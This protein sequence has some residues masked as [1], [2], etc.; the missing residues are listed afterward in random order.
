MDVRRLDIADVGVLRAAVLELIQ[1]ESGWEE[2]ASVDHLERALGDPSSYFFVGW[3]GGRVVGYLSAYRFP[4]VDHDG[5]LVYLYD[6]T[7]HPEHR[8]RGVGTQL[9]DALKRQCDEDDVTEIWLGTAVSNVGAQRT[10]ESTGAER[11]SEE[12]VEYLYDLDE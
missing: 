1:E 4:A 5:F 3:D 11:S 8:R 12:F 2:P 9:I 10:F 6:I 7:V